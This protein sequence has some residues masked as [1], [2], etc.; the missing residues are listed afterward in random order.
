MAVFLH[1]WLWKNL[2]LMTCDTSLSANGAVS[3]CH[4]QL[5]TFMTYGRGGGWLV[6]KV[7][8]QAELGHGAT[9]EK[10]QVLWVVVFRPVTVESLTL[11]KRPARKTGSASASAHQLSGFLPPP[12]CCNGYRIS[13]EPLKEVVIFWRKI[14]A[15]DKSSYLGARSASQCY[16]RYKFRVLG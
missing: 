16:G 4:P 3:D 13:H 11:V 1:P 6:L 2:T 14:C 7:S 8:R 10:L 12:D 9:K 15:E 5:H